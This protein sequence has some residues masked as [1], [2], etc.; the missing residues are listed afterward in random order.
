MRVAAALAIVL[1]VLASCGE[2]FSRS[3]VAFFDKSGDSCCG[4]T[5]SG[6]E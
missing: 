4:T 2:I 3:M 1:K 5:H 6:E